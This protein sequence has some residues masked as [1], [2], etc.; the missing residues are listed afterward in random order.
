MSGAT[1]RSAISGDRFADFPR[2]RTVAQRWPLSTNL[3]LVMREFEWR[4][5]TSTR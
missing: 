5:L 2:R 1:S 3:A 4:I